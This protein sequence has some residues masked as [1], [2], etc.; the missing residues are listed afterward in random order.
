M[1]KVLRLGLMAKSMKGSTKKIKRMDMGGKLLVR[2]K[3]MKVNGI[4]EKEV[5]T[6]SN[7]KKMEMFTKGNLKMV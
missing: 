6:E 1:E 2:R 7:T 5:D 3:D 4:M